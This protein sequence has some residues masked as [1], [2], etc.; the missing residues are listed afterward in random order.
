MGL[1]MGMGLPSLTALWDGVT[2]PF[3]ALSIP[4][5]IFSTTKAQKNL[6]QGPTLLCTYFVT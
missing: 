1:G 5:V 6:T 2:I 3:F 4:K